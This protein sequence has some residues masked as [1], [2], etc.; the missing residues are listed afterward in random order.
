MKDIRELYEM[1]QALTGKPNPVP[2]TDKVVAEVHGY[3]GTIND[4]IYQ[5]KK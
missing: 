1:A 3:D 5:I 4:Y 2:F